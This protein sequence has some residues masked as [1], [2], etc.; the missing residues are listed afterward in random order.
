MEWLEERIPNGVARG[1]KTGSVL[2]VTEKLGICIG[3]VDGRDRM[4]RRWCRRLDVGGQDGHRELMCAIRFYAARIK[5]ANVCQP[6]HILLLD[7]MT[8]LLCFQLLYTYYI[9]KC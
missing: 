3:K 7:N 5:L 2:S 9:V 8:F 4:R 6:S 1:E